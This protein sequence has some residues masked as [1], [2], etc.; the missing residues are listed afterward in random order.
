METC[1][2]CR[3][4]PPEVSLMMVREE[5]GDKTTNIRLCLQCAMQATLLIGTW[6]TRIP[7]F[8][9]MDEMADYLKT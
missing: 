8:R 7:E 3:R 5:D 9:T 4:R 1:K 6:L 2:K